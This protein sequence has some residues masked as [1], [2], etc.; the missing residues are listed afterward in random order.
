[1]SHTSFSKSLSPPSGVAILAKT[2]QA[3]WKRLEKLERIGRSMLQ[4]ACERRRISGCRLIVSAE[5]NVCEAEPVNQFCDVGIL[6]QSQFSSRSP[7]TTARSIRCEKRSSFVLSWD[8]IGQRETKVIT[9]QKSSPGSGSQMLFSTETSDSR[10][11][12]CVRRLGYRRKYRKCRK[13]TIRLTEPDR[14]QS[15]CY[16]LLEA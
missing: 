14:V 8:L 15:G 3:L 4:I 6:S 2:S 13:W 10:K 9:S 11:H 5:N 1:M 16:S 7:R 12:V